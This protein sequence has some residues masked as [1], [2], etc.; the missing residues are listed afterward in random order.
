MQIFIFYFFHCSFFLSRGVF[1]IWFDGDLYH[2]RTHKCDTFNN[3]MLTSSE[4]FVVKALEAWAFV[5]D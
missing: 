5:Q 1:G 3:E 2:G 4:D